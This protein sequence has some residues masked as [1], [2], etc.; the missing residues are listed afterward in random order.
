M[1]PLTVWAGR[2]QHPNTHSTRTTPMSTAPTAAPTGATVDEWPAFV[3]AVRARFASMCGVRGDTPALFVSRAEDL[4]ERFLAGL[5]AALAAEMK[6]AACRAFVRRYGGLVVVGADGKIEPAFWDPDDVP[7]PY[8]DGVRAMAR[9]TAEA[10]IEA[11]FLSSAT[12]WGT[13]EKGGWSHFGLVPPDSLVF[14]SS[15]IHSASQVAAQKREDFRTLCA[16]LVAFPLDLVKKAAALLGTEALYRS[17][18][19]LGVAEWLVRLH[20]QRRA[21]KD[22]RRRE[23]LTWL[24]V[25]TAPPGF[26]HVRST[27]IGTLL[28]DL[29]AGLDFDDVKA[30]FTAKMHPLQY[31][32]PTA[33]P[34]AQNIERAEKIVAQLKSAGALERRFARLE[35][36]RTFWTPTAPP[37][38][39][40]PG[41]VFGHLKPKGREK[42]E[43]LDVPPTVMTWEKFQRTV[44][45]EAAHIKYVVPATR[46]M[47]LGLVTAK[48][49]DAPPII[50]WDSP[51]LRNPVTPYVYVNGSPAS[52]WNLV[53]GTHHPV[54]AITFTPAMWRDPMARTHQGQSVIF[55]LE[56]AWD[57][58]Y[59]KGAGFFPEFLK[60]EY[61]EIRSTMEAYAKSAVVEGKKEAT[62]CGISLSK[63]GPWNQTFIVTRKDGLT[64]PYTLDRWD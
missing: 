27:M 25:A 31:Q 26:C 7:A 55:L 29:G 30:R 41:G 49:P 3:A 37:R 19:V 17:E 40:K 8:V 46:Q 38:E 39:D 32:R 43:A 61:H 22:D 36:I 28:E 51:E 50:Q 33:A 44:L 11:V 62:A 16:A 54:T 58:T 52:Q 13:P 23:A 18:K 1:S 42:G 34:S 15:G 2:A 14:K 64:M 4:Y 45:A 57:T 12:S 20:E 59:E 5:T 48:N 9:A 53:P 63:G 35:D 24:A 6:C 47:F 21:A 56:G 60:S 10:P